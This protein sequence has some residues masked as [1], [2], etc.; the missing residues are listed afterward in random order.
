ME[1]RN[2][3]RNFLEDTGAPI[4]AFCKRINISHTYFYKWIN[5]QLDFSSNIKERIIKYLDEVYKK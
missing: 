5:E 2:R 1:L 3:V 4:T